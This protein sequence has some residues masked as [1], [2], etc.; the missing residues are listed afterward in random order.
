MVRTCKYVERN[1]Q[2]HKCLDNFISHS[3]GGV[4]MCRISEWKRKKG[5]CPYDSTIHSLN[6]KIRKR[7]LD[8]TQTT[9]K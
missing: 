7:I 6:N 5:V 1:E 3:R 8:K 2:E 9:L 4:I